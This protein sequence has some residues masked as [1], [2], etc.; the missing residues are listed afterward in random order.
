MCCRVRTAAGAE[1]A[2]RVYSSCKE[3]KAHRG[4][5]LCFV[6]SLLASPSP[7]RTRRTH[8]AGAAQ[9]YL[10]LSMAD[11]NVAMRGADDAKPTPA[12]ARLQPWVEKYRPKTV[13][14]VAHQDEVGWG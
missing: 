1:P 7:G 9:R 13:D 3:G 10:I 4:V 12:P 8:T 14:D 2:T 11:D 5:A 6:V